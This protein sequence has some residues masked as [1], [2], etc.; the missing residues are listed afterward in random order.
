GPTVYKT[1]A[2]PL[3]YAGAD[4]KAGIVAGHGQAVKIIR[5][6]WHVI[7]RLEH[8]VSRS[9]HLRQTARRFRFFHP[10]RGILHCLVV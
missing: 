3:S 7:F 4:E 8:D 2:L 10:F 6:P 5:S 1:V 9:F